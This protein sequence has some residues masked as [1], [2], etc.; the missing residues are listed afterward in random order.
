MKK[1][2][3]IVW[4]EIDDFFAKDKYDFNV[5]YP[6][7]TYKYNYS[8]SLYSDLN[9]YIK[10]ELQ[11]FLQ[12]LY[13]D[14]HY[15]GSTVYSYAIQL[16][17]K[18]EI[19]LST[20]YPDIKSIIEVDQE[21]ITNS[22]VNY[23]KKINIRLVIPRGKTT[24][25]SANMEYQKYFTK[26]DGLYMLNNYYKFVKNYYFPDNTPEYEKDVWN[27]KNLGVPYKVLPSRPRYTINY[28]KI[29]QEWLKILIKKYNIKRLPN[30]AMNTILSS[31]K[32]FGLF[33]E[34]LE[35]YLENI[36]SL[37]KLKRKDIKNFVCFLRSK[38]MATNS[39]NRCI[40]SVKTFFSLGNAFEIGNFPKKELF[41]DSD[42]KKHIK[43]LPVSFSDSELKQINKYLNTL[44]KPFDS[45]L[46][47]IERYGMRMSDLC[48]ALINVNGNYCIK[49]HNENFLFTYLQIKTH[50]T[51][52]IVIDEIS[53]ALLEKCISE[54]Q[55]KYGKNAKYIFSRTLD[56]PVCEERFTFY[57]NKMCLENKIL[58]DDGKILRIKGHTFRRTFATDYANM[59]IDMN[60]IRIMLGQSKL[61]VLTHYIK[62]HSKDMA[63]YLKPIIEE[64]NNLIES[65]GQKTEIIKEI[66]NKNNYLSLSCGFCSKDINS[67]ICEHA[68]ACYGCSMF[69]PIK[70][71]LPLYKK[72]LDNVKTS[73]LVCK[74]NNYERLLDIN[75]NLEKQL[76][77]IIER[78][79]KDGKDRQNC[80]NFN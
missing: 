78:L 48:S 63:K 13:K 69:V 36:D 57:L 53:A 23:L 21:Q 22:Y 66:E 58:A 40:S 33:S 18:I 34:F 8:I 14:L 7:G 79:E 6:E 31:M 42:F 35:Q 76:S 15:T 65:I 51:N 55:D 64:D 39:F 25:I 38:Q 59:G 49:K 41:K 17:K 45:I 75:L 72:Q 5:F 60:V 26:Y 44:P 52:T 1:S 67:G 46:F 70:S 28:S 4:H 10:N 77:N 27:I 32:A 68:N 19:V 56:F 16:V 24:H 80:K 43:K 11:W 71:K 37:A 30:T 3:R 50:K 47:I 74:T 62:I 54:S 12:H 9:P 20:E 61:D 29:H 73:I 2:V